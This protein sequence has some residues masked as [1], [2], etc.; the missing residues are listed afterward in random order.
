M[1]RPVAPNRNDA[2]RATLRGLR[3]QIA[4]M[5]GTLRLHDLDTPPLCAKGARHGIL[6]AP[7]RSATGGG[8][9]NDVSVWHIAGYCR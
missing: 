8:V 1:H 6:R 2:P 4:S 3:R 5:P 9:Q 7:C